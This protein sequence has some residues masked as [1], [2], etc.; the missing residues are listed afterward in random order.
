MNIVLSIIA[1]YD[2]GL[3]HCSRLIL[4]SS[5]W[6][7]GWSRGILTWFQSPLG[8]LKIGQPSLEPS[9]RLWFEVRRWPLAPASVT[10]WYLAPQRQIPRGKVVRI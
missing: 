1:R 5:L 6:L 2:R 7:T 10:T 8:K 4:P 3:S 9:E